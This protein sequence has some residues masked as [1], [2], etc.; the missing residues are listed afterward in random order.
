MVS[1]REVKF[2]KSMDLD[3]ERAKF[4]DTHE[5]IET[6]H[7]SPSG[8]KL[9]VGSHDNKIYIYLAPKYTQVHVFQG[10]S[11]FV[12]GLDWS[13]DSKYIRSTSAD[14]ELLYW[15]V[16]AKKQIKRKEEMKTVVFADH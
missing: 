13:I 16:I 11:N 10:H 3:Q 9:A 12:N 7:Y 1:I 2:G 5:W 6:M 14:Y 15:D 4:H 8:I